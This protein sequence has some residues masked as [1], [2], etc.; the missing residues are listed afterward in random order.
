MATG[1]PDDSSG[2]AAIEPAFGDVCAALDARRFRPVLNLDV[3]AYLYFCLVA[4]HESDASRVHLAARVVGAR[5]DERFG[6][7]IG[8]VRPGASRVLPAV[9]PHAVIECVNY[10]DAIDRLQLIAR[11]DETLKSLRKLEAIGDA[12]PAG[13]ALIVFDPANRLDESR[14]RSILDTHNHALDPALRA[15]LFHGSPAGLRW[16]QV[17]GR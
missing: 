15:Y 7:V 5:S 8:A 9:A 1:Q 3:A 6:L 2:W 10:S 13:R 16:R 14:R 4:R 12:C 11:A 17:S